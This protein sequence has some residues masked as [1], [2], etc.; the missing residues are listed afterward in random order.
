MRPVL[1]TVAIT[2]VGG[3]AFG[4]GDSEPPKPG[5]EHKKLEYFV[6]NWTT[7]GESKATPFSPARKWSGAYSYEW[8]PGEFFVLRRLESNYTDGGTYKAV[9]ILGYDSESKKYTTYSASN[10]GGSDLGTFT[11]T[12][13]TWTSA[14]QERTAGG[15]TFKYR[16]TLKLHSPDA[17][18]YKQ[19][20]S[21]DDGKTWT[22]FGHAKDKRVK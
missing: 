12:D 13:D 19:E 9:Q 14:A 5:P 11:V 3:V 8:L 4:Q 21:S 10:G 17:F 2:L 18:D 6:G 7:E 15:K 20:Y 22:A 1:W 16:A